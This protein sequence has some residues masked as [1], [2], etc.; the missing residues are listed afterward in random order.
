MQF[1]PV[2]FEIGDLLP[3]TRVIEKESPGIESLEEWL[4]NCPGYSPILVGLPRNDPSEASEVLLKFMVASIPEPIEVVHP[5]SCSWK[6]VISA[7]I[8]ATPSS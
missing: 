6:L 5:G 8:L 1:A 2:E 3:N 4:S 7:V